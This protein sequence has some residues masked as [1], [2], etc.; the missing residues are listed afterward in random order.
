M[1][2]RLDVYGPELCAE[3]DATKSSAERLR[4][5]LEKYG[6]ELALV[7]RG[8]WMDQ[9]LVSDPRWR[10]AYATDARSVFVRASGS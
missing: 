7:A 2:M 1:D 9:L 3:Y 5:Y 6:F 8:G 4:A 10:R